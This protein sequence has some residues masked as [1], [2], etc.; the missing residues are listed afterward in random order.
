MTCDG[1]WRHLG[2]VSYS[3]SHHAPPWQ[4]PPREAAL[5]DGKKRRREVAWSTRG[6]L[7]ISHLSTGTLQPCANIRTRDILKC[8]CDSVQV[9]QMLFLVVRSEK[10]AAQTSL[11]TRCCLS[12]SRSAHTARTRSKLRHMPERQNPRQLRARR[13]VQIFESPH[14]PASRGRKGGASSREEK[15]KKATGV[16]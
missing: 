12:W 4:G 14:G 5:F 1:M 10:V 7:Q 13:L 11:A 2:P 16:V 6:A 15:N 3:W 8:L 9:C